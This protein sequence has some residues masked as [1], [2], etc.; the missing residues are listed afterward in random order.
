MAKAWL[1]GCLV[2]QLKK[3]GKMQTD[4]ACENSRF[5]S[6]LAAG[7]VSPTARSEG[8]RLF[9]Q[10]KADIANMNLRVVKLLALLGNTVE[11]VLSGHPRGM[12]K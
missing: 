11:P 10:A 8:K 12:A 5:P 7:D 1:H 2:T 9:S 3:R 4:I 6:L